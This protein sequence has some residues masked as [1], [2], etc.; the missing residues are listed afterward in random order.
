MSCSRHTVL[1]GDTFELL[2]KLDAGIARTCV[3]SPPYWDCRKYGSAVSLGDEHDPAVYVE[4]VVRALRPLR[5]ILALDGHLW[6]NLGDVFAGSG[7][8]RAR[9]AF[10]GAVKDRDLV[11]LPWRVAL[12]LQADGWFLRC[13]IVWQKSDSAP[14]SAPHRPMRAHEYLFL[15]APSAE[16]FF[17]AA[18]LEDCRRSVWTVATAAKPHSSKHPARFPPGLVVPCIRA[19]TR[20][21]DLVL[22]PFNGAGTTGLVALA[23]DRRYLGIELESRWAEESRLALALACPA[24]RSALRA[25][26]TPEFAPSKLAPP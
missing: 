2:G 6:L 23:E 18:A 25:G 1:L 3:T 4:E 9:G 19:T 5:R 10:G 26:G 22:D 12:A 24:C 20:S 7:H 14:D 11:G 21:G 13:D 8:P 17:D 15:L 16:S